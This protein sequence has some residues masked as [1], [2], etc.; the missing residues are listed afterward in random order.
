MASGTV[1]GRKERDL[2][3]LGDQQMLVRP[4]YELLLLRPMPVDKTVKN[5]P[6]IPVW[7]DGVYVVGGL[8]RHSKCEGFN[9]EE[10]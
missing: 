2:V 7:L 3:H 5:S 6:I 1:Y 4:N 9:E 10:K 8:T